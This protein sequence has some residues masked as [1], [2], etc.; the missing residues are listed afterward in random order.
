MQVLSKNPSLQNWMFSK[1]KKLCKVSSFKGLSD[2][3]SSLEDVFKS[4]GERMDIDDS[5]L[6]SDEDDS[7]SSR[8]VE[9]AYL[10]P[11][12][13]NKHEPSSEPFGKDKVRPNDGSYGETN[14]SGSNQDSGRAR[15]KSCESREYGDMS[16]SRS[17]VPRELMNHQVLSPVMRSPLDFRS[18]S[19]DGR[20]HANLEKNR[21][22]TNFG[23]PSL[24]CSSG[25]VNS[26]FESPNYHLVSPYSSAAT[27]IIWYS[28]GDIG[29]MDIFSASKELW[30]G[31][32]GSDASEGQLRYQLERFGLVEK[33]IFF[34]I[35]GFALVEYRNMLDAIKAREYIR[36]HFPWHIK[37]MDIGLGTRGAMNGI[38][39]GSSCHVYVGNIE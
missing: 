34:P 36:R 13:S 4:F 11:G 35:K 2:I 38:A 6:D 37:F 23:S 16:H 21:D 18:N 30:L 3:K 9:R 27:Q 7:D 25:G 1:Y 24:R 15:S 22:G 20:K 32:S 19:F 17:S 28:D 29:A 10:M 8:L 31:F 33:F 5:Q 26:S 14:S 39:V 12:F